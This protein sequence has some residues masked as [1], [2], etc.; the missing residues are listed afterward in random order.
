MR[1]RERGIGNFAFIAVLVLFVVSTALAFVW[2]D[3]GDTAKQEA[4]NAKKATLQA[5]NKATAWEQ[6]YNG[7]K[8]TLGMIGAAIDGGTDNIPKPDGIQAFI[9]NQLYT[10]AEACAAASV[11]N[12]LKTPQQDV[13]AVYLGQT[14]RFDKANHITNQ[15]C[16]VWEIKR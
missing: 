7:M 5:D 13:H 3:E 1:N 10:S 15:I 2:K 4:S 16:E 9:R 6:A 11:V 8:A 14:D 12:L